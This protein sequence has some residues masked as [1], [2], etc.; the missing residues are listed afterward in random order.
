ML[1][2]RVLRRLLRMPAPH[3][4]LPSGASSAQTG[5]ISQIS[6]AGL[7]S[8]LLEKG[9]LADLS[10]STLVMRF[11][12]AEQGSDVGDC[13]GLLFAW[14]FAWIGACLLTARPRGMGSPQAHKT[15]RRHLQPHIGVW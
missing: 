5:D 7:S 10:D 13:L 3:A 11:M 1:R 12:V 4:T 9:S 6:S 14:L 8:H 15:G 2:S